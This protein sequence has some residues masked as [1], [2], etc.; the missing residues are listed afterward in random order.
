[1]LEMEKLPEFNA[2]ED[3][4]EWLEVFECRAACARITNEKTKIQ[5]CRSVIGSVGRRIL[6]CLPERGGWAKAKEELRRYLGEGDSSAAAWKKLHG[7]QARGKCYG[8]IASEVR[9]LAVKAADEEDV[10][11]RLAV[12]AFLGRI[13]WHFAKEIRMKKIKS[14][15]EALKEAKTR[16]AIEE[17]VE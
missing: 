1:M 7:Y 2:E 6:K 4:E 11:E 9:E 15:E 13:P 3:I 12:E 14:L 10:Q 5:G 8:E 17:E 16:R